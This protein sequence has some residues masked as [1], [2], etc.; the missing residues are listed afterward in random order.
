MNYLVY[1]INN[2]QNHI[3]HIL[4][5]YNYTFLD[6][7]KEDYDIQLIYDYLQSIEEYKLKNIWNYLV[8]KW[9]Y[10]NKQ[11]KDNQKYKKSHYSK[12]NINYYHT[13]IND[14]LLNDKLIS[15][16]QKDICNGIFIVNIILKL[17]V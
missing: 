14:D 12:I 16:I 1:D 7:L 8:K 10:M 4:R 11:L 17:I 3:T 2:I 15:F 13:L 5:D 9:N 6:F